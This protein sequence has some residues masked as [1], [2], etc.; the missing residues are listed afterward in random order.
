MITYSSLKKKL[1]IIAG[2]NVIE[3]ENHTLKM[4]TELKKIFEMYDVTFVFKAS[5]DKANRTSLNSYR[6]LGFDKGLDILK[7]IKNKLNIPIITDIHESWQAQPVSEVVDIIQIPAF[8]CRQTDLLMAAAKTGKIIHVK[9]GQMCSAEQM[10]KCK[11]KIIHFG[12]PNVI[13]CERGNTFGYQDLVVDPRNLIW[14][15]SD[16]NLVSMDVTHCLQQPSQKTPDGTIKCGGYRNLIP[17]MAKVALALD[18]NG[19]F[20]EI[21]DEPDKALCDGPTQW[22]LNKTT[23][24][25][26]VLNIPKKKCNVTTNHKCL[27]CNETLYDNKMIY[28]KTV[29]GTQDSRIKIIQCS[30]C[31]HIQLNIIP[32]NLQNHYEQ[33]E[34]SND[35][36]NTFK[37]TIKDIIYKEHLEIE[38]RKKYFPLSE[39][40]KILDV[41]SGYC[42]FAKKISSQHVCVDCIEPSITRTEI[43]KKNNNILNTENIKIFNSHLDDVFSNVNEEVYDFVTCWHVIEHLDYNSLNSIINNM[44]KCCKK[45]GYIYIEVPNSNDEL[46]KYEKYQSITY[47]VH[48][49]SYWNEN[50]LELLMKRNN[51]TKYKFHYEQRYGFDNYL[52]WTYQLN[53]KQDKDMNTDDKNIEWIE[54]KKKAKNTDAIILEIQKV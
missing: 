35:I 52:N 23:E 48:H 54:A 4:A 1:F 47:I 12:N 8:L 42:S 24:L 44:I 19:I 17:Y 50:T 51:I 30:R 38:R 9:K 41:G 46:L 39:T 27:L 18:V 10:H 7:K 32:K 5:I 33:D 21:H 14:L 15:K 22:P 20:M 53:Q 28:E 26:N 16:L 43:G 31:S 34:Q 25:L 6:G 49:L 37:L 45:G 36:K 13:L 11:E 3:N 2:P 40:L 29:R